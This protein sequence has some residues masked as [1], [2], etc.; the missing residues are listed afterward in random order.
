MINLNFKKKEYKSADDQ[1][2][3]E[4]RL[5]DQLKVINMK[6]KELEMTR[7]FIRVNSFFLFIQIQTRRKT[8]F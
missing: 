3:E 1:K 6:I 2:V 8:V 5:V 4:Q 7:L